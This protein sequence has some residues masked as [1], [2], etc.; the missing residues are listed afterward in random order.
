MEPHH[1]GSDLLHIAAILAGN[2]HA[3]EPEGH[4]VLGG[5]HSRRKG[6]K[7]RTRKRQKD[8][9]YVSSTKISRMFLMH[10]LRF[11]SR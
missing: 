9:W 8:A 7:T 1:D 5:D 10:D 2:A 3:Q 11:V 4:R 6:G